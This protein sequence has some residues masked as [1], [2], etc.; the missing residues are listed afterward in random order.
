M[1][2]RTSSTSTAWGLSS[3]N[4]CGRFNYTISG[5]LSSFGPCIVLLPLEQKQLGLGFLITEEVTV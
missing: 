5:S 1:G 2:R 3:F 4:A